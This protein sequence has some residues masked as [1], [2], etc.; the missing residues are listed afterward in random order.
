MPRTKSVALVYPPTY[1]PDTRPPSAA[2][3]PVG[4]TY[5]ARRATHRGTHRPCQRRAGSLGIS[6]KSRRGARR[7][8]SPPLFRAVL[9]WCYGRGGDY[10][11]RPTAPACLPGPRPRRGDARCGLYNPHPQPAPPSVGG[12]ERHPPPAGVAPTKQVFLTPQV[13]GISRC[14]SDGSRSSTGFSLQVFA[15]RIETGSLPLW[16]TS[17]QNTPERSS[18]D[19]GLNP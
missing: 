3:L 14:G 9:P 7:A 6:S 8:R 11:Q 18:A 1:G 5:H 10:E 2:P 13:P 12:A 17:L 4:G 16:F 19:A 15:A